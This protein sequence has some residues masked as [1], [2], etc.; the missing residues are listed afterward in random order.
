LNSLPEP[1][2]VFDSQLGRIG[3]WFSGDVLIRIA[4]LQGHESVAAGSEIARRAQASIEGFVAGQGQSIDIAWRLEGTAFQKKVLAELLDIPYGEVRTY[5]EIAARLKTSARAVGNACRR[6]PLPLVIPC[7][8]VV[9]AVGIGGYDG[10]QAGS[11]LEIKR[12][13][14]ENEGVVFQAS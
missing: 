9:A 6:N 3:L 5:G 10:A 2:T 8:R 1:D 4:Y 11:R 12:R 14:L 7:H 13:L